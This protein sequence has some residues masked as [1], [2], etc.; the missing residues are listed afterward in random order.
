M[1]CFTRQMKSLRQSG[2][3]VQENNLQDFTDFSQKLL[4]LAID[5]C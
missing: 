4:A 3:C 5:E 1:V 2:E